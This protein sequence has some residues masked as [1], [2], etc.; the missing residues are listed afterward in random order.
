MAEDNLLEASKKV[1]VPTGLYRHCVGCK[2]LLLTKELDANYQVCATCGHHHRI[3]A[4]ARLRM[5][6]DD[7]PE[8]QDQD[9]KSGDPL[10]FH[11]TQA[12]P[13]RVARYQKKTGYS[14]A[15]L[16]A[17]G[18]L[19]GHAVEAGAF[20]FGF[21]GGSMGSVVGELICRQIERA[22]ERKAAVIIV[23]ASGG[24]RMQEG[25]LSLMQMARVSGLLHEF[26][27][28]TLKP[29]VSLLSDPTTG[30]VAASFAML[31]DFILAEPRAL[32]GFAGRRVIEQTI[33]QKLP[34]DFQR[35]EFLL[36]HGLIDRVV[37]RDLV[38]PTIAKLLNLTVSQ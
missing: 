31:G 27:S 38:K 33:G 10:H 36:E 37:A 7:E 14:D 21:M 4:L 6:L 25:I 29:F 17:S 20:D 28:Q 35:A 30:G 19:E 5:L 1:Q 26:R 22:T 9:V 12:Y 16:A 8:L 13:D 24:A 34:E 11:D 2:T 23:S 18:T 3:N 15:Y 32:I